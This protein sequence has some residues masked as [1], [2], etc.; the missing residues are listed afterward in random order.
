MSGSCGEGLRR[1]LEGVVAKRCPMASL[2]RGY[3]DLDPVTHPQSHR[4]ELPLYL[5]ASSGSRKLESG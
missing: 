2:T 3:R 5:Q 4:A 1:E